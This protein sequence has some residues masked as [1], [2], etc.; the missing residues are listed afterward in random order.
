M[1]HDI[2]KKI[3]FNFKLFTFNFSPEFLN[4]LSLK[5]RE[6]R[7]FAEEIIFEENDFNDNIYFLMKGD[8]IINV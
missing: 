8:I 6:K 5:L 1:L 3:L 2:N 4:E 7:C